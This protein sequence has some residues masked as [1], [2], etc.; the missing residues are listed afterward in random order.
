MGYFFRT[1]YNPYNEPPTKGFIMEEV[2]TWS[3]LLKDKTVQK[4]LLIVIGVSIAS[5]LASAAVQIV[6]EKMAEKRKE[7]MTRKK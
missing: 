3:E 7:K 5:G 6:A 2:P 4:A 1:L